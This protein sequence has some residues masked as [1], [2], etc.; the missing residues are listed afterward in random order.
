MKT[1]IYDAGDAARNSSADVPQWM[2]EA[3]SRY[4][5]GVSTSPPPMPTQS[6]SEEIVE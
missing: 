4:M 1:A 5:N 3:T 6:D 2:I